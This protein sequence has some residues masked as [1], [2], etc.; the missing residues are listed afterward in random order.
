MSKAKDINVKGSEISVLSSGND[1]YICITDIAKTKE[2]DSRAADIIKNWI[3]N[4]STL[5]FIGTWEPLYN[6][7]FKVVEFDHFK[8]SA[9]L[10][11]FVLSPGLWIEKTGAIGI[12]VNK[13]KYGGTYAHKDIAFE[14]C[15]AISPIFKIYLIKEFQRLKDEEN[16]RLKLNWNFQRTLAKVNYKIHTDAIKE[17]LIPLEIDKSQTNFIYANEADLLN[18]ALFGKTAKQWREENSGAQGN[19]RDEA[20]IE[21]LVVL[22][23]ME[24]INAMLIHQGI[25]AFERL[26]QLNQMAISQMKSLLNHPSTTQKLK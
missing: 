3:R 14:F 25:Q 19:Q 9:G 26:F 18:I 1:D 11:S 6:P 13:G 23:N 12:Y 21:Q 20:T 2:S 16:E 7:K 24:S 22:S 17:N 15:S 10:P 8:M 4:R 5:E